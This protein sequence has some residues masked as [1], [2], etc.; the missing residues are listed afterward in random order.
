VNDI[1]NQPNGLSPAW[2]SQVGIPVRNLWV[3]LAYAADL[4]VFIDRFDAELDDAARY[5][6]Y[7][8]AYSST[9]WSVAY[10]ATFP[11]HTN[12]V[13]QAF[14]GCVDGLIGSR[15]RQGCS[16]NVGESLADLRT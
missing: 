7:L 4:A 12:L 3:L 6:T 15:R 5:R 2:R 1:L 10:G 14:P 13:G 8:R 9:W 11:E 16:S